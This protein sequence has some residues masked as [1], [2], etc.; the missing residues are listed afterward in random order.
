MDLADPN[1][2]SFSIYIDIC[3]R[4]ERTQP[5]LSPLRCGARNAEHTDTK[6]P[7]KNTI[8]VCVHLCERLRAYYKSVLVFA[9]AHWSFL[10][11]IIEVLWLKVIY[12][13]NSITTK[14]F[15][16]FTFLDVIN[17]HNIN[18]DIWCGDLWL[19]EVKS[20]FLYG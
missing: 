15:E 4:A 7:P 10:L 3:M 2:K 16:L 17:S 9:T 8:S 12:S 14:I 6:I 5:L 1:P 13:S 18:W 19:C 11:I 20:F